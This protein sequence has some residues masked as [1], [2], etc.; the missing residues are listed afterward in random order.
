MRE[1]LIKDTYCNISCDQNYNFVILIYFHPLIILGR[2]SYELIIA[3]WQIQIYVIFHWYSFNLPSLDSYLL[4]F[5]QL[6][7]M[8]S[9]Q[10]ILAPVSKKEKVLV[11]ISS[12]YLCYC[13]LSALSSCR[14]IGCISDGHDST[15]GRIIRGSLCSGLCPPRQCRHGNWEIT[16]F[17]FEELWSGFALENEN[18]SASICD[19]A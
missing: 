12:T 15:C 5:V 1:H 7:T 18:G 4:S 8:D 14:F 17:L 6:L 16:I 3:L 2:M 11:K 9:F 10:V 13:D 19:I